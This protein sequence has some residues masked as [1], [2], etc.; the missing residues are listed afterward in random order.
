MKGLDRCPGRGGGTNKELMLFAL[1]R[2]DPSGGDQQGW[3]DTWQGTGRG[4]DLG[5]GVEM[6]WTGSHHTVATSMDILGS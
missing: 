4:L 3:A 1:Q 2:G 6:G 5:G